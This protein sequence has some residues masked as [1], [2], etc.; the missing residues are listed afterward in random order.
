MEGPLLLALARARARAGESP[1]QGVWC[2]PRALALQ[3][4]ATLRVH[5]T[6]GHDLSLDDGPWVAEQVRRWRKNAPAGG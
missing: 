4:G 2:S 6:A 5:G 3:W 1:V